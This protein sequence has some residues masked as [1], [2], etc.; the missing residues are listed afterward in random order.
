M[1][2]SAIT[3]TS[4]DAR[5]LCAKLRVSA[6][7]G[8]S[9]SNGA[10]V[11]GATFDPVPGNN[12][13]VAAATVGAAGGGLSHTGA[14]WLLQLVVIGLGLLVLGGAVLRRARLSLR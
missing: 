13:A 7:S 9:L 6:A 14:S 3:P 11:G 5:A 2:T 10:T 12:T 8:S 4:F 1:P